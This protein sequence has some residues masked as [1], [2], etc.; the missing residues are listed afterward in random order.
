MPDHED[1]DRLDS[2]AATSGRVIDR[3]A[4]PRGSGVL[5][6]PAEDGDEPSDRS[7]L[8]AEFAKVVD[9]ITRRLQLGEKLD[10]AKLAGDYPKWAE[11]L[12]DLMPTLQELADFGQIDEGD[13][14]S[15]RPSDRIKQT[16]S[17]FG[18][19]RIIREVGRGGMGIVYEAEQVALGRRVALKILPSVAAMD[20]RAVR[21]FQL[22]SQVAGCLQHPRIVPVHDVG[23]VDG[24]PFFAMQ[25]IEGGSLADLIRVLDRPDELT[26]G[27]IDAL[28]AT[29]LSG[30]FAPLRVSPESGR[31]PS[32]TGSG[33][34][35]SDEGAAQSIRDRSYIRT[36]TRLGIQAADA[37][38]YAHDQ[39]VVHRDI[40]PANLLLDLRG[41]L[42]VADFG[43]ADVR[44]NAGLTRTGD[45]PGTLRYMSPEQATGRRSLV[46]RRTD[47]YS[48]G[49]TLYELLTLQPAVA[50]ADR[51]EIFR[52]IVEG[53]PT[54]IRRLNP[55]VPFELATIL[56]KAMSKEPARRYETAGHLADDLG[57]FLEGR[58]IAARPVG[59]IARTW[60]WCR[61]KPL[62]AGMAASLLLAVASGLA[63]IALSWREAVR[64]RALLLVAEKEA[65]SQA[66]ISEAINRFLIDRVLGQASPENNPDANRITL[67]EVLD[68]AA[69][70]VGTSFEGQSEVEASIRIAI[71]RAYHGLGENAR[72]EVHFRAAFALLRRGSGPLRGREIAVKSDLG[73]ALDHL[74]RLDEA[75]PLLRE[76]IEESRLNLEPSDPISLTAIGNLADLEMDRGHLDEAEALYRRHLADAGRAQK[77]DQDAM[78]TILNNL[79]IVLTRQGKAQEAETLCRPLV[80]DSRR[81]R[82]PKHPGTLSAIN[83]LA[84]LLEKQGKY[85]EAER[86]F[87]QVTELNREVLGPHHPGVF[88][89]H[90]NL[91]H[92]LAALGSV[93]EAEAL[94]RRNLEDQRRVLG[95]EHPTTLFTIS[96]LASLLRSGNRLDEAE[97][98]LRPCLD[99]QR[100]VLGPSHL[101]TLNT[102]RRL[103]RVLLERARLGK[104]TPASGPLTPDR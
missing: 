81:L 21:R 72:S 101:D 100:R 91:A 38:E 95:P 7:G 17:D 30:R 16:L 27:G 37:L 23:E 31:G 92:V 59:P 104:V 47:V 102:T 103:D 13:G 6:G 87:R 89:A 24:V 45:L 56:V 25:F 41:D 77:P 94:F 44:G 4:R 10:E 80:E 5:D 8:D 98:L 96:R 76:A 82:G 75:E 3:D 60:R 69:K 93:D 67:L 55:A 63:G 97:G 18:D 11:T 42:W 53:E 29:L 78:L 43:M 71:G 36:I 49:A 40:K 32:G 22:E 48:L 84:T 9:Q 2:S 66:A 26:G 12:R 14:D 85:V 15:T 19:F 35:S 1:R 68:R 62:L 39:G 99:A 64:Q 28:A 74:G 86:L 51:Q 70:D 46:D 58:P 34:R 50:D 57:R 79:G 90:F 88:A 61:R 33:T 65:R 20:P 54:P 73:H 83:N 52:R